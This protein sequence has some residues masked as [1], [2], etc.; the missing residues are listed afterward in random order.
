M[1]YFSFFSNVKEISSTKDSMQCL[2]TNESQPKQ[3]QQQPKEVD[4]LITNT[5]VAVPA[6]TY[7]KIRQ[8]FIPYPVSITVIRFLLTVTFDRFT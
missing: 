4:N 1:L 2:V 5:V 3:Q 6:K 7:P 8:N